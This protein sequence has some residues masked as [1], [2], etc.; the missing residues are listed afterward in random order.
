MKNKLTALILN[1]NGIKAYVFEA[2]DNSKRPFNPHFL[3]NF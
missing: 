3:M 1:A 2:V